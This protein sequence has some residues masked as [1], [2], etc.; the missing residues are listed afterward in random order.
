MMTNDV[1]ERNALE[2]AGVA[3]LPDWLPGDAYL[4]CP[5]CGLDHG[6]ARL[7]DAYTDVSPLGTR[8]GWM[9]IPVEGRECGHAWRLVIDVH[10]D[11]TYIG[12]APT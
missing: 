5:H 4:K 3:L 2:H 12:T 6:I 7:E 8:G 1:N 9:A 10:A 11:Q